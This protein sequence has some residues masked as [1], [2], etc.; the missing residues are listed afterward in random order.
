MDDDCVTGPQWEGPPV[1]RQPRDVPPAGRGRRRAAGGQPSPSQQPL[2][3]ARLVRRCLDGDREAWNTLFEVYQPH[4]LA[5]IRSL[6]RDAIGGEQAEDIASRVWYTLCNDPTY[7]R[8]RH[9]DPR[10]GRFLTYLT[11]IARK[12]IKRGQ[13]AEGNRHLRESLAARN[14]AIREEKDRRILIQEFLGTLTPRE[15][16]YCLCELMKEPKRLSHLEFTTTN[17]YKLHS[18]VLKKFTAFF[19]QGP[20]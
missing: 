17:G 6:S 8:L 16:E 18:R 9:F 14:E 5:I 11:G 15:R 20:K 2:D 10:L 13:R 3:E 12:E 1:N 7:S 19:A 4:L